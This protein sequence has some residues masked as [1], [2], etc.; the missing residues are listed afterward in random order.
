MNRLILAFLILPNA[1]C[2][3][4]AHPDAL[5]QARVNLV[6]A[7]LDE[8]VVLISETGS[9]YC[10]GV[11]I[12]GG[13]VLTADHCVDDPDRKILIVRRQ[14]TQDRLEMEVVGRNKEQD[15]AA[16]RPVTGVLTGGLYVSDTQ[17]KYGDPVVVIGHP[18][19]LRWTYTSGLVSFPRRVGGLSPVQEWTQISAP[20]ARGNSGGPVLN[21]SGAVV[22]IASFIVGNRSHLAGVVHLNQIKDLLN[23]L[24][25]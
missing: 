1:G 4:Q 9:T 5:S 16:L 25:H 8:T 18:H 19:G 6:N 20:I 13:L 3:G 14:N 7:V 17:L 2:L 10:S 11:K 12:D 23:G 21:S 15:I 22:G 24:A